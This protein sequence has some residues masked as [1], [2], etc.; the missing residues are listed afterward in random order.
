MSLPPESRPEGARDEAIERL[1]LGAERIRRV[2]EALRPNDRRQDLDDAL[3]AGLASPEGLGFSRAVALA[4]RG[5][6]GEFELI[7]AFGAVDAEGRDRLNE[8]IAE[9]NRAAEAVANQMEAIRSQGNEESPA[10]VDRIDDLRRHSFWMAMR[11]ARLRENPL[12]DRLDGLIL[13][14]NALSDSGRR[15]LEKILLGG[16][17]QQLTREELRAAAAPPALVDSLDERSL[18]A[19]VRTRDGARRLFIV[20]RAFQDRPLD[21]TDELLL[22]WYCRQA[23]LAL[24]NAALIAELNR[25]NEEFE[26]LDALKGSFLATISH[27]LRNP[28]TAISGFTRLLVRNMVGPLTE[29]QQRILERVLTHAERLAGVVN[30]LIEIAEIDA[31]RAVNVRVAEVDALEV[32]M[33]TLPKLEPRRASRSV[34]IEPVVDGPVA[35]IRADREGLARIFYHLIDNAIKFSDREGRVRIEFSPSETELAIRIVDRGIGIAPERLQ[36]IFEAFYQVDHQLTRVYEGMGIGLTLTKKLVNSTGGRLTAESEPGR[37]STFT[38]VY[39]K[40]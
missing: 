12:R 23:S 5:E 4:P 20:D 25:R 28:L 38:V 9:E 40:A 3:L 10:L 33:E 7:D 14:P 22:D 11:Q 18:W 27:E 34:T 24:E 16:P 8:R 1:R 6:S 31:A 35:R 2:Q 32:L 30:D 36:R 37:G 26:E 15:R 17:C 19:A 39:P 13:K 29:G 21:R